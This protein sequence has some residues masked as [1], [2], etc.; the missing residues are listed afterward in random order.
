MPNR[1]IWDVVVSQTGKE[2]MLKPADPIA[3]GVIQSAAVSPV[4]KAPTLC[5]LSVACL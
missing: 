4:F 5:R 1:E 3:F 2:G